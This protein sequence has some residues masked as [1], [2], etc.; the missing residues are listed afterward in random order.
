V[1]ERDRASE[2][3]GARL[4]FAAAAVLILA[5][6]VSGWLAAHL[7]FG[8]G[9]VLD[10]AAIASAGVM[11]FALVLAGFLFRRAARVGATRLDSLAALV[12]V[13]LAPF[14]FFLSAR[15]GYRLMCGAFSIMSE[16]DVRMMALMMQEA[17]RRDAPMPDSIL[18]E[19]LR[20]QGTSPG[21]LAHPCSS[22]R[23]SMVRVGRFTLADYR[24]GRVTLDQL[25]AEA[26]A[27]AERSPG[28]WEQLGTVWF[29]HDARVWAPDAPVMI[30]AFVIDEPYVNDP[31]VGAVMSDG[32]REMIRDWYDQEDRAYA[33]SQLRPKLA[34]ARE[35]G[36]PDPPVE[37][38]A[39]LEAALAW[40]RK[41]DG[42]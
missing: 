34:T 9:S 38:L 13:S 7:L 24:S 28:R 25:A 1:Q 23:P 22:C 4:V 21:V 2:Y 5:A 10:R 32:T 14:A 33:G 29:L 41:P 30:C 20:L 12:L 11:V 16:S 39:A 36:V 31:R 15:E 42:E 17:A 18:V 35:L 37:V 40:P 26:R 3:V 27:E 8:H 6:P 19:W